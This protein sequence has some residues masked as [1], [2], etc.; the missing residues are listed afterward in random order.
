MKPSLP[1]TAYK[2]RRRRASTL[3]RTTL[4]IGVAIDRISMLIVAVCWAAAAGR[5]PIAVRPIDKNRQRETRRAVASHH[6]DA[7]HTT[8][9]VIR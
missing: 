2:L 1:A 3:E 6:A 7:P 8:H 4:A 9:F 5:A